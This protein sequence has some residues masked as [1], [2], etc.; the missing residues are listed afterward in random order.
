M[1]D[2]GNVSNLVLEK[3][4]TKEK[5]SI[6]KMQKIVLMLLSKRTHAFL[7]EPDPRLLKCKILIV[8]AEQKISIL[9]SA[10]KW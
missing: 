7:K 10:F 5:G 4:L 2:E 9:T 6:P 3:T 1:E 8:S